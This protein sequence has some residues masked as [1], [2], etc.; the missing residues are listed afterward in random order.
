MSKS[1]SSFPWDKLS[2]EVQ[3]MLEKV[4]SQ[5]IPLRCTL[6]VGVDETVDFGVGKPILCGEPLHSGLGCRKKFSWGGTHGFEGDPTKNMK[7][8]DLSESVDLSSSRR[9]STLS[10]LNLDGLEDVNQGRGYVPHPVTDGG[11]GSGGRRRLDERDSGVRRRV[12][13]DGDASSAILR[14]LPDSF[15]LFYSGLVDRSYGERRLDASGSMAPPTGSPRVKAKKSSGRT[16]SGSVERTLVA[17]G[18]SGKEKNRSEIGF[19]DEDSVDYRKKI[20][21]RLRRIAREIEEFLAGGNGESLKSG[22]R[23]CGG[24]CRKIGDPEWLFCPRCGG[25]MIEV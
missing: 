17:T 1:D 11:V 23:K 6:V 12:V 9:S 20:D 4:A 19:K 25:P 21:R 24:R 13:L 15:V 3:A 10:G 5:I 2:P 7:F 8:A 16:N 14:F 18:G 22:K